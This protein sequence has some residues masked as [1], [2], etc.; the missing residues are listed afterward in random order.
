MKNHPQIDIIKI[1]GLKQDTFE[2][3]VEKYGQQFKAIYF[4]KNKSIKDL[5]PLSSLQKVE[6]I[7]YFFNQGCDRLWDMNR[8]FALKGLSINDFSK[9]HYIDEIVTAPNLEFFDFG[10][11]EIRRF[12]EKTQS[13]ITEQIFYTKM[14]QNCPRKIIT[15]GFYQMRINILDI[16]LKLKRHQPVAV[17]AFLQLVN[18]IL[19]TSSCSCASLYFKRVALPPRI[20]RD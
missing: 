15:G 16:S 19:L 9:L 10:N 2:Y 8:N 12:C 3:F 4:F 14:P 18:Y 20:L 6:F 7:G 5:S 17:S 1:I 11:R 13:T